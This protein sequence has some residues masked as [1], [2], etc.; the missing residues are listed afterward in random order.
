MLKTKIAVVVLLLFAPFLVS[1]QNCG[2][3]CVNQGLTAVGG[4]FPNQ[5]NGGILGANSI[6]GVIGIII[7]LVLFV[8]G[9]LA[10]L[11]VVIGGITYLTARGDEE[12]T[13]KAKKTIVNAL[14]G[15]IVIIL[16][17]VIVN[18][19]VNLVNCGFGGGSFGVFG[20]C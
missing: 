7:K 2:S 20:G 10:V 5:G 15:I 16:S 3:D 12:Q 17:Y 14:I 19:I 13:T 11:F 18:V 9:A 8:A 1:A 6:V 4:S